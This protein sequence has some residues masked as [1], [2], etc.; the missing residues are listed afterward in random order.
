MIVVFDYMF[1][2]SF[3]KYSILYLERKAMAVIESDNQEAEKHLQV[4][5]NLIET[6]E[7]TSTRVLS[8]VVKT[9]PY[10][11]WERKGRAGKNPESSACAAAALR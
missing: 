8:F 4:I 11:F 2:F 1:V 3:R 5:C 6:Q 9:A 10:P 7:A